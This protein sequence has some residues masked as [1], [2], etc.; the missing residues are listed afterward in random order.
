MYTVSA[1]TFSRRQLIKGATSALLLAQTSLIGTATQAQELPRKPITLV[2][3]FPAGGSIDAIARVVAQKLSQK[4]GQPVVVSNRPGAGGNIA[5]QMVHQ[6][7]P[8][9]ATLLL[10]SIGSLAINPHL[11]KLAHDP[12]RDLAPVTMATAFPNVLVVRADSGV[13]TLQDF[14]AL[15][16]K[17]GPAVSYASGGSGSASH[18]AGELLNQR[19]GLEAMHVPFQGGNPAMLAVLGG[20]VTAYYAAPASAL[21][22]IEAKKVVAIASTGPDRA[23]HLPNVPTIAESGFPGFNAT[24]WYA[25]VLPGKTPAAIVKRWNAELVSVLSAADVKAALAHHGL[26]PKPTTPEETAS[27]MESESKLWGKVIADRQ[28]TLK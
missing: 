24:N 25:F 19:A 12:L 26:V 13:K 21:P 27:F 17:E 15:A 16:K 2:V 3:G 20:Q 6:A 11:M 14:L 23:V 7:E 4:L 22:H 18:L 5:Q 8:D 1:R 9:G 28:I 10:G